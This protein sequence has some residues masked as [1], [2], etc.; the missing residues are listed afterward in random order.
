M[1]TMASVLLDPEFVA[2]I[3]RIEQATGRGGIFAGC[4]SKLEVSLGEFGAEFAAC[5]KSGDTAG[6]ARAAHTL[7][8]SY[9]QL[10]AQALGELFADIERLA[11]TGDYAQ[12]QRCF[13][14][15]APLVADS[16]AA[17][18]RA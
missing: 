1:S 11:K 4:V 15:G 14:E 7:K 16:I 3:R 17:L 6:A 2:E 12:A 13:E 5:V 10:G 8:G 9:R 18:K